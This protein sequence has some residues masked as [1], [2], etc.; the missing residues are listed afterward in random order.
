MI[1]QCT[2]EQ[3]HQDEQY[4]KGNR[5]HRL[6]DNS[7]VCTVCATMR[8]IPSEKA[9]PREAPIEKKKSKP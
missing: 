5:L 2:C 9:S 6:E 7:W 8:T 3:A 4:G 1:L